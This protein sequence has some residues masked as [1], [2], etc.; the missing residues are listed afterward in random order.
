MSGP[1]AVHVYFIDS[2]FQVASASVPPTHFD[3]YESPRVIKPKCLTQSR[4]PH[5]PQ[6]RYQGAGKPGEHAIISILPLSP[7]TPVSVLSIATCH[8]SRVNALGECCRAAGAFLETKPIFAMSVFGYR[9]LHLAHFTRIEM[10][11]NPHLASLILTSVIF[12]HCSNYL[13]PF[14]IYLVPDDQSL[15][16]VAL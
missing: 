10:Y 14:S 4:V 6:A 11:A 7:L 8:W 16:I 2:T 5:I 3:Y 13:R 1:I 15:L 12:I 9:S